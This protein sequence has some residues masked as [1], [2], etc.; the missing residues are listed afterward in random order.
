MIC[1]NLKI[2]LAVA[3]L[4]LAGMAGFTADKAEAKRYKVTTAVA[5]FAGK[6]AIKAASKGEREEEAD[7]NLAAAAT[8]IPENE[9]D[10]AFK[11]VEAKLAAEKGT[12]TKTASEQVDASA[13]LTV[14]EITCLAG[15][16]K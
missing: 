1:A 2:S 5:G 13:N 6:K 11:R 16:Y 4:M 15:C 14:N 9:R 10:A 12:V 3:G 8:P 7:G